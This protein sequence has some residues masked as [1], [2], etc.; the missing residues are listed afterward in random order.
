MNGISIMDSHQ[1]LPR[2]SSASLHYFFF[3]F[4]LYRWMK[5]RKKQQQQ[6]NCCINIMCQTKHRRLC[7]THTQKELIKR[8]KNIVQRKSTFSS[9]HFFSVVFHALFTGFN[10]FLCCAFSTCFGY[11]FFVVLSSRTMLCVVLFFSQICKLGNIDRQNR[12]RW[13]DA[14]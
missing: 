2:A 11:F 5:Q 12:V 1:V 10:L 6:A 4:S 13:K 3:L 14:N 8:T 9:L 7:S